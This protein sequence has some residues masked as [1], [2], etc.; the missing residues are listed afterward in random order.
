MSKNH[1]HEGSKAESAPVAE[2]SGGED[3][4]QKNAA[5]CPAEEP[6]EAVKAESAGAKTDAGKTPA[7]EPGPEEIIADLEAQLA[8]A[9]DQF[10]R[11]AA[12][13]ENFRKR[14]IREKQ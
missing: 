9:K 11:K 13:F 6:P 7:T 5:A 2:N 14:M 10:L 8:E 12:D 1:T 4:S 3:L